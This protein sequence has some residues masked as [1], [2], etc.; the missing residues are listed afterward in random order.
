[1]QIYRQIRRAA[2]KIC[3]KRHAANL[4][5]TRTVLRNLSLF[6]RLNRDALIAIK[7]TPI[8]LKI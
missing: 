5:D 1:M 3:A 2:A 8:K 7:F 4:G 6:T